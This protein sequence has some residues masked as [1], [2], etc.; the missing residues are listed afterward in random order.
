MSNDKVNFYEGELGEYIY[1][2]GNY[3]A[4]YDNAYYFSI[5]DYDKSSGIYTLL[6]QSNN[7][8]T[9]ILDESKIH[10]ADYIKIKNGIYKYN[11]EN[12]ED[13]DNGDLVVTANFGNNISIINNGYDSYYTEFYTFDSEYF[14][15]NYTFDVMNVESYDEAINMY[16]IN[17]I[18][19]IST[20]TLQPSELNPDEIKLKMVYTLLNGKG[21][22]GKFGNSFNG[23]IEDN[24]N[25]FYG[26]NGMGTYYYHDSKYK[27]IH[28]LEVNFSI[29]N[30]D[31]ST[32]VYNLVD[33]R[34]LKG[35]AK[36]IELFLANKLQII[37]W[38]LIRCIKMIITL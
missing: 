8:G 30:Y 9:A 2:N 21:Y 29:V 16:T 35:T 24:G 15:N 7:K 20:V 6:D 4:V 10:E 17:E 37:N 31:E 38:L 28:N 32:G 18:D 14:I 34:N 23:L 26:E 27:F 36:V 11:N 25:V 19:K 33:D 22:N 13:D 3:I 1:M 12:Y 5:V